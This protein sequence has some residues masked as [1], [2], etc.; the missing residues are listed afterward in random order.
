[1]KPDG[2]CLWWPRAEAFGQEVI[3]GRGVADILSIGA[4]ETYTGPC[5]VTRFLARYGVK[6]SS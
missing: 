2:S 3:V 5:A 4:K 1:M 6:G